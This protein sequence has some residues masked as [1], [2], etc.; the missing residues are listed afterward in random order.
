MVNGELR[1]TLGA[2]DLGIHVPSAGEQSQTLCTRK[3]CLGTLGKTISLSSW[4]KSG[5]GEVWGASYLSQ[6]LWRCRQALQGQHA[7]DEGE[8]VPANLGFGTKGA[9]HVSTNCV[10]AVRR[11]SLAHG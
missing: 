9:W 10:E 4:V 5:T 6:P 1:A 2:R 3:R 7:S 11:R 8:V